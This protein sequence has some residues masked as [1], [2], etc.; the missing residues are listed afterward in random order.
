MAI[1]NTYLLEKLQTLLGDKLLSVDESFNM[2]AIT[3]KKGAV[4]EVMQLLYND[5]ELQFQFLTDLCGVHYPEHADDLGV[6]YHLHS[7]TNNTRLRVRVFF[8]SASETV[9]SLTSLFKTA[10][11]MERETFDFYGISFDGH[12]NMK[13]IL[14]I[15]DMNYH[16]MLKQYPLEDASRIDKEDKYFGR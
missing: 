11:W 14:N 10:N 1:D 9:P 3:V 16:P 4:L 12:P 8:N 2:A 13:R 6:I 7:L 15:D 5:S